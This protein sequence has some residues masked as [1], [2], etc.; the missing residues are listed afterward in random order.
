MQSIIYIVP[1]QGIILCTCNI[2]GRCSNNIEEIG[3][4]GILNEY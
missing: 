2:Q 1:L 4:M 3:R